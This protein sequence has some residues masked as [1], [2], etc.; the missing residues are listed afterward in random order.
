MGATLLNENM[1]LALR[2]A[3]ETEGKLILFGDSYRSDTG[4]AEVSNHKIIESR[5]FSDGSFS[6][7]MSRFERKIASPELRMTL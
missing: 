5:S 7:G 6:V 1:T 2:V 3:F 4:R